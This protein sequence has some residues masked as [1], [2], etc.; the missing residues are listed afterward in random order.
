VLNYGYSANLL[1]VLSTL[2]NIIGDDRA[3]AH[4]QSRR[5]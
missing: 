4:P 3:L 2:K 5:F 1:W